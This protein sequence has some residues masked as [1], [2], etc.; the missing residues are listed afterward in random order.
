MKYKINRNPQKGHFLI[1]PILPSGHWLLGWHLHWYFLLVFP[2]DLLPPLLWAFPFV[3][4]CYKE[5]SGTCFFLW[6][7]SCSVV[8]NS[9]RPHGLY[10]PWNSPGQNTGVGSHSLL[11]GIFP[12]QGSNP[13]LPHYRWI[14][15]HLSHQGSPVS[16]NIRCQIIYGLHLSL[17]S[18]FPFHSRAFQYAFLFLLLYPHFK[19]IKGLHPSHVN[20]WAQLMTFEQ[21]GWD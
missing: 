6:S 12:T 16:F 18:V 20:S 19:T 8:S 11:Q 2:W 17:K 21:K 3:S 4:I 13:G 10:S 15:Y 1:P 9:L 5:K 7:E 14:L